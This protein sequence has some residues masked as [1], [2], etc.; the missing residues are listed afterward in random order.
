MSSAGTSV[1]ET[2]GVIASDIDESIGTD[3]VSGELEEETVLTDMLILDGFA[4]N[5]N[6]VIEY[7]TDLE[8]VLND[9]MLVFPA[10]VR[11]TGIGAGALDKITEAVEVYIPA[12]IIS[13]APGALDHIGNLMYIEVAPDNPVYESRDGVLYTKTGEMVSY[14]SGR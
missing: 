12:N 8:V 9:G 2:A 10:D 7:C 3:T 11:C 5:S 13:I 6:G 14:P 1:E 4:I